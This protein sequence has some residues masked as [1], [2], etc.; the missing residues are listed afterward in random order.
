MGGGTVDILAEKLSGLEIDR[1]CA[2]IVEERLKK[3]EARS[4]LS[5]EIMEQKCHNGEITKQEYVDF[6]NLQTKFCNELRDDDPSSV[7]NIFARH[8]QYD[9][10]VFGQ[11]S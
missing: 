1:S 10:A 3:M 7:K 5:M 8:I 9:L 4:V 6:A 2:S 11:D